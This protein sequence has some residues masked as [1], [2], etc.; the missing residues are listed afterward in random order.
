ML[1]RFRLG[2]GAFVALVSFIASIAAVAQEATHQFDIP[3]QELGAALRAYGQQSGQQI[4]FES[5]DVSGKLSAALIGSYSAQEGLRALLA[6]S[7]LITNR[8]PSGVLVVQDPSVDTAPARSDATTPGAS[9]GRQSGP[10][11]PNAD[12][13]GSKLEEIVV[14]GIGSKKISQFESSVAISTFNEAQMREF[15]PQAMAG[16]FA[17]VPGFWTETSSG[18][19]SVNVFVRGIP[20]AG[21]IRFTKLQVDGVPVLEDAGMPFITAESFEKLSP[22]IRRLEV[23]R[24]GT[25]TIY[26]SNAAGGII[27]YITRKGTPTPE[28]YAQVEWSDYG[29]QRLDGYYSGALNDDW[30]IATGGYYR[31]SDGVRDPGFTANKGGSLRTNVTYEYDSGEV[32]LYGQFVNDR[33]I[34]YLPIPLSLD[35]GGDLTSTPGFD[36]NYD[37][38]TSD[39]VR[40]VRVPLAGGVRAYDLQDGIHT[41]A[42][43][44]GGSWD[45]EFGNG[46][47][48]SNKARFVDGTIDFN[49]I[50][51]IFS[52]QRAQDYLSA[53]LPN[54]QAAFPGASSLA[55]RYAHDGVGNSSTFDFGGDSGA[56]DSGNNGNGLVIESGWWNVRTELRSF[57]DDLRLSKSFEAAGQHYVAMGLYA[58]STDYDINWQWNNI[59]QEVNGSPRGL[60][61]YAVNANGE[62]VGAVTQN[63][64]TQYGTLW[65]D[66]SADAKHLAVYLADE[67]QVTDKLRIDGGVRL[68][69]ITMRGTGEVAQARDLSAFNPLIAPG[70]LQTLADDAVASGTGQ[71]IP[72]DETYS[73]WAWSVGANYELTDS[74]AFFVRTNNGYRTPAPLDLAL[75]P[76][77]AGELPVNQIFQAEGGIKLDMRY[78]QV[79]ATLFYSDFKDQIFGDPVL[80]ENGNSIT[81]LVLLNSETTGFEAEIN[82]GPFGGFSLDNTITLQEPEITGFAAVNGVTVDGSGFIGND[83][84]RIAKRIIH[85]RP[86]YEFSVAEVQG[87]LFLDVVNV[88]DRFANNGNS[89][90][91]PEYTT[92]GAGATFDY[93]R[94][95]LTVVGDNL[96]NEIGLQEGNP[97]ADFASTG[98]VQ[99]ATFGRPILGRNFRVQ[100][101]YRF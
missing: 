60:D 46:W 59:L 38:L 101:G 3:P 33:T 86:R 44:F 75:N 43:S 37:T 99:V 100:L 91:L 7:G 83:I 34:F 58:S 39:D 27:N 17:K 35:S 70:G 25:G 12:L 87:S 18:E 1:P 73:E 47:S 54:A 23:V 66:M 13:L 96:T 19:E 48:F 2:L 92:L 57:F 14:T 76:S 71:R 84:Q 32:N 72:F 51:S 42:M 52:P 69:R 50:F 40:H 9:S 15:A 29:E 21:Q 45:H 90:L 55:L 11:E 28:G 6:G 89:V 81:A 24:G 77:G 88:G 64:F 93:D 97:R 20:A 53:R 67:W 41:D 82:F 10:V 78:A 68:E 36:A 8:T 16:L 4:I 98:A 95:E 22:M 31:V 49:A 79:F 65:N 26:A 80:D 61:I 56:N 85:V 63:T 62:V 94:F 30:K 74:L 5:R